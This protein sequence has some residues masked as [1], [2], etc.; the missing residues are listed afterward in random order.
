MIKIICKQQNGQNVQYIE[1]AF[2]GSKIY[3]Y[4]FDNKTYWFAYDN[5][6]EFC[7]FLEKEYNYESDYMI[8]KIEN[9]RLVDVETISGE[10]HNRLEQYNDYYILFNGLRTIADFIELTNV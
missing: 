2:S 6:E 4:R 8:F 1:R 3:K 9:E 5:V 7:E 10:N